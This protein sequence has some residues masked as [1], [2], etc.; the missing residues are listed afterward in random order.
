ELMHRPGKLNK[1]GKLDGFGLFENDYHGHKMFEHGGGWAGYRSFTIVIPEKRFA[2]AVLANAGN[3]DTG[4]QA[5][6]I[7][8]IYL[9][10]TD[11]AK[12]DK[13]S[14]KS[15]TAVKADPAT[16]DAFPGTYRL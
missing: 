13:K 12:S 16:W 15:R 10:M 9:G 11:T 14:S 2:V 3:M 7:A 1:G 6:K 8:D 4:K 5:R